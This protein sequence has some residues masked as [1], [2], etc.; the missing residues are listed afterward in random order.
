MISS[1]ILGILTCV[2]IILSLVSHFKSVRTFYTFIIL[3]CICLVLFIA[4]IFYLPE[5]ANDRLITEEIYNKEIVVLN[6]NIIETNS[7]HIKFY[8]KNDNDEI[9]QKELPITSN[10][11]IISGS[12]NR[13]IIERYKFKYFIDL[14]IKHLP[15]DTITFYVNTG[16]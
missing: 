10:T 9:E 11:H 8:V 3:F 15:G 14:F 7:N 16:N 6:N 1:I 4:S 5:P 13:V 2:F 12:E